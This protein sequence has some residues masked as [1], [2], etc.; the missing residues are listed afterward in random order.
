MTW[1]CQTVFSQDLR[2]NT[3]KRIFLNDTLLFDGAA[4]NRN[5]K[6][7]LASYLKIPSDF[8]FRN[9]VIAGTKDQTSLEDELGY[10]HERYDQYYKGIKIEHSDVRARFLNEKLEGLNGTYIYAANID[11][12]AVISETEAIR[13]SMEHI[14]AKK[15]IWE[16]EQE[17]ERLSTNMENAPIDLYPVPETVIC[18]NYFNPADTGF[19]VAYKVDIR[20][21]EPFSHHYVYV[22]AK[23]GKIL[24]KISRI[25]HTNG[26]AKTMYSGSRSISIEGFDCGLFGITCDYRLV[27]KAGGRWI[28]TRDMQRQVLIVLPIPYFTT[29]YVSPYNG[30]YSPLYWDDFSTPFAYTA[31]ALD[32]HW[33]AMETWEYFEA[34]HKRK[35]YDNQSSILY[36]Y[37][38]A[39]IPHIDAAW[40]T[41]AKIIIYNWGSFPSTSLDIVAHEFG[42]GVNQFSAKIEYIE[43]TEKA[44][45]VEGLSDIWAVCVQNFS[46]NRYSN[47]NKN[48]WQIGDETDSYHTP[49]RDLSNPKFNSNVY[50]KD[51]DTYQ[52]LYWY[53]NDDH[54]RGVVLGHWFYILSQGKSGTNDHGYSYNVSGITID[55]AEK[56]V[57]KALCDY[58]TINT[59]FYDARDC[60]VKAAKDLYGANSNEVKSVMDAWNAVGVITLTISGPDVVC[61]GNF[62]LNNPPSETIYWSVSGPF[63]IGPTTGNSTT[64]TA[65]G[66]FGSTPSAT[67]YARIGSVNGPVVASKVITLCPPEILGSSTVCT[68]ENFDINTGHCATVWIVPSGFS[69]ITFNT[70]R[71]IKIT[72]NPANG[73]QGTLQALLPG[74]GIISKNIQ[75]CT[76]T[77]N[78]IQGPDVVCTSSTTT[79]THTKGDVTFWNVSS[80]L[81]TIL[82]SNSSQA[83][84]TTSATVGTQCIIIAVS[85]SSGASTKPVNAASCKGGSSS[86]EEEDESF[87]D[88]Y[89]S[90]YPN[91]VS[92][93]LTVEIDASS[94]QNAGMQSKYD[95]VYDLRLYDGQ[96]NLMRQASSKGGAVEFNVA[97]LPEGIYYLHVYDGVN[98]VPEMLQ[99][100]VEH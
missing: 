79:F 73:Q 88:S 69:G 60:T 65:N 46:N 93:I 4:I 78:P 32:A 70:G 11:V 5:A 47:L 31:G 71:S 55:K 62:T 44:A 41:F 33:G 90:V 76:I 100:L 37:T 80:N 77:P 2:T 99:I 29:H 49:F 86:N 58:M 74:G 52:G 95:S 91:P 67:L 92:G 84:I 57:Y 81:F 54:G 56:I 40:D 21:I 59:D 82:S 6:E 14:G 96:G 64:V 87:S 17:I 13:K 27:D 83:K 89:I 50:V 20:A 28:E 61:Q 68:V 19:Y 26:T 8:E 98:S 38:N 39:Q 94:A 63:N 97:N 10:V 36:N 85:A 9:Q 15:Y 22:D 3:V 7:S 12:S 34:K 42:H 45:V 66:G 43:E 24:N 18:L 16:D 1:L 51:P 23:T 25:H 48:I 72:A 35:S 75:A 30:N 53:N